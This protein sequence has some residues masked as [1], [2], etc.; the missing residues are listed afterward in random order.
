MCRAVIHF[1]FF[2]PS[3]DQVSEQS[4][5]TGCSPLIITQL[6]DHCDLRDTMIITIPAMIKQTT[7]RRSGRSCYEDTALW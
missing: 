3:C 1:A 4:E 6:T 5:G 2:D 7:V